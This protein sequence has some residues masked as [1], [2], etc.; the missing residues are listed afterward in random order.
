MI[1]NRIY[2][3]M[4]GLMFFGPLTSFSTVPVDDSFMSADTSRVVD[5]DE[6][7]VVSHPKENVRLR[8]QPVSSSVFTGRE[9]QRLGVSDLSSLSSYVPSFVMP[10]YGSRLTSSVYIRGIGSRTGSPAVGVYYDGMPLMSKSAINSHFYQT[11]RVDILRGPQGTLYGINAEGGIVRIFSKNPL[12]YQGTDIRMGIGTGL[13]GNVEVAHYHRPSSKLAFSTAGFYNGQRGFFRNT[14][15]DGRA[16]LINEAGGKARVIWFP[17]DRLKLD[18]TADYQYTNQNGFAYGQYYPE[19][20]DFDEPAT[21][22]MNGFRR[23]MLN[24]AL[25]I[26]Y[27]F[28]IMRITSVSSY[29]HLADLMRMDQ[30]YLPEDYLRLEQRERMNALVQE[31]TL[32]GGS[33]S[34]WRHTSG[35]FFSYQWLDTKAPVFFG[36]SMNNRIVTSMGM[37]PQVAKAITLTE[38]TVPGE[39]DTPQLNLGVYHESNIDIT[40]RLTATLGLRYDYQRVSIDYDTRAQFTLG[41]SGMM[42]GHQMNM[43]N[44]YSSPM[45]SGTSGDYNQLLP[46]FGLTFRTGPGGSN[47]YAVVSK[48][49]RAGGYNLQM[50]SDIFQSEQRSLGMKLMQLLKGDMTVE[51]T[52]DDYDRINHTISYKPETSWNYEAGTHLYLLGGRVHAD[53]SVFLMQI[54]NQQLSVMADRYGYGRMMINAGRSS[55]AGFEAALRG[56]AFGG[57]MTWAGTYSYVHSTFRSY[58][59]TVNVNI[60]D[61]T[62]GREV[63][64][65]RG[66]YVPFV[67]RHTFSVTADYRIDVSHSGFLRAVTPGIS[68][69]GNGCT[70][71]DVDNDSRQNLYATLGAHAVFDF[72][73]VQ[74]NVW[75]RNL[76][77][78]KYNT[79]L[80][81]SSV[82]G[83]N[84]SFTQRGNPLRVGVD[85]SLRL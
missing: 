24:T 37:P 30:D 69:S 76:T 5:L 64:N 72:G 38:N 80:V 14:Y 85:V 31:V 68:V 45:N 36:E 83:V 81:N 73:N 10:A 49:F 74:V 6:V 60:P 50:F 53:F 39:F 7:V 40:N 42:G 32:S 57:K 33:G 58:T 11:D 51:H 59:D 12:N 66:H 52:V 26:S 3:L 29:Q 2:I 44:K 54:R 27:D 79:F 78:T 35:V 75:G 23:Q 13:Y 67:P 22:I 1:M 47:I 43:S 65:Y 19:S 62:T 77:D 8:R 56:S 70:Y 55:S 16:D 15:L 20:G 82:Y 25:N 18:L 34:R 9:M 48:G 28:G 41:Y 63:R 21:T 4:T 71:W 84:R 17:T 61:G 46:K